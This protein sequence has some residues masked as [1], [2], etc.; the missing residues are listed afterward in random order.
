MPVLIPSAYAD[1]IEE[2]IRLFYAQLD[3]RRRDDRREEQRLI[4]E[5][6]R[7]KQLRRELAPHP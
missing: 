7:A 3:A 2:E 6:M 1:A 5:W 4:G